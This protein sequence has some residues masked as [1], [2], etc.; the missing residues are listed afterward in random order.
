[1]LKLNYVVLGMTSNESRMQC[2]LL[3]LKLTLNG[4]LLN[5]TKTTCYPA[6]RNAQQIKPR[7]PLG[8]CG[9]KSLVYLFI[10]SGLFFASWFTDPCTYF[11]A[12]MIQ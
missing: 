10:K 11:V 2:S 8:L 7:Y 12:R 3:F 1:M 9:H 4:P 5:V 6:Q